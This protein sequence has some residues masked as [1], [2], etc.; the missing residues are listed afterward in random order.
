MRRNLFGAPVSPKGE[1]L[2]CTACPLNHQPNTQKVKGLVRIKGRKAMLWAEAPGPVE[3]RR[4]RELVGPTSQLLWEACELYGMSRSTFD[5]QNV[6]RCQPLNKEGHFRTPDKRELACCS[7]YNEEALAL[8]QGNAAV[9]VILGKVAAGQLLGRNFR[10]DRPVFWH[11]PWDCYIVLNEHPSYI[12]RIG[13]K[14]AGGEYLSWRDRFRAVAAILRHPGRWGFVK[15]QS[16]TTVR[17]LGEFDAMEKA[18]RGE[19]REKRRVSLDVEDDTSGTR[20]RLLLA[21]FGTG[22]YRDGKPNSPWTGRCY[23]VVLDHPAS[24]YEPSHLK[25]MQERVKKLV[26]DT[27]LE[28][29]LQN[30]TYDG[31]ALRETLGATLKGYTYDTQYGTY[32]KYSWLRS[33]SLE[34]LTYRFFPEF[35]DYKDVVEDWEG[36]YAK[37]PIDRLVLRNCGD[38]DITQRLEQRF[39]PQVRQPLVEVY[40]HAAR[41]LRRMEERGPLLDWP[42]WNAANKIVPKM[43]RKLNDDLAMITDDPQFD[44]DSPQQVA[45]FLYDVLKL[46][47]T[48][49]GRSTVKTVLEYLQATCDNPQANKAIG[50][51]NRRRA[52]GKLWNTYLKGFAKSAELHADMLH[53]IWWLTG[54]VTGRLRSGKGD[55]AEAEGILNLQNLSNNPLLQNLVCSDKNWRKAL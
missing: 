10:A 38:C 34:N 24:G 25:A 20:R 28:K 32:L 4:G 36:H 15:A 52:I 46:P 47:V 41:T 7:V 54:T 50:R 8:N 48:E 22:H 6:C 27:G 35:C 40:I 23:S 39:G 44:C 43:V 9:H 33:C 42:N 5:I 49:A 53:T 29:S 45:H 1:V 51:I 37:A 16:Y 26:E 30:G 2:G 55:R 13:G 21:G 31:D 19:M 11:A 3:N 14:S 12:S 17:T 18:L